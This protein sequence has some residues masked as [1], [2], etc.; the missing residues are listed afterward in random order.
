MRAGGLSRSAAGADCWIQLQF[1]RQAG[2]PSFLPVG[3]NRSGRLTKP[4]KQRLFERNVN[5]GGP[6]A[7]AYLRIWRRRR[8]GDQWIDQFVGTRRARQNTRNRIP[9][10]TKIF[11]T[12]SVEKLANLLPHPAFSKATVRSRENLWTSA[13]FGKARDA[14]LEGATR[15]S[16]LADATDQWTREESFNDSARNSEHDLV[17]EM[18]AQFESWSMGNNLLNFGAICLNDTY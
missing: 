1:S 14:V 12:G 4:L 9:T 13:N 3:H 7:L 15:F 16:E 5:A 11:L 6:V 17:D 18:L 2:H 8:V 10:S